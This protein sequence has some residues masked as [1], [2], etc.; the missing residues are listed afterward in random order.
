MDM[1]DALGILAIILAFA[2]YARYFRDIF[3]QKTV[4]HPYSWFAWC[5]SSCLIFGLQFTHGAG[6][7]AYV[8]AVMAVICGAIALLAYRNGARRSITSLDTALLVVSLVAAVLWL[9]VKQPLPSMILLVTAD[10]VAIIPSVRKAWGAPYEE[11]LSMWLI[12][13]LRHGIAL[14]ALSHYSVI[15]M[16]DP[17]AWVLTNAAFAT[18][19]VVRRHY[20]SP[21]QSARHR[22]TH[23]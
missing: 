16:L 9:L 18:L 23:R 22:I 6:P 14:T 11:T 17:L 10:L 13:A 12:N 21:L 1:K 3:A 8:T 15:T 20:I 7:G 4:P 19:L 2:A 5:F